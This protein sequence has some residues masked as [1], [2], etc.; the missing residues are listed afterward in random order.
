MSEN[1]IANYAS[2]LNI[3]LITGAVAVA[4]FGIVNPLFKFIGVKKSDAQKEREKDEA[5]KQKANVGDVTDLTKKGLKPSYNSSNYLQFADTVWNK[6]KF[7]FGIDNDEQGA[8]DIL[9]KMKNDLDVALLL[10]AYGLRRD[11]F[12]GVEVG[13]PMGLFTA[14][15]EKV[16]NSMIEQVNTDWVKKGIT[17]RV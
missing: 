2:T 11:W 9:K 4:Y 12:F 14:I 17:Y 8:V 10:R 3:L 16:S 13:Q 6:R 7:Q 15:R 5:E 1:R